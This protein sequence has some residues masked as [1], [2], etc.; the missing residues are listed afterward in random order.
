MLKN[1]VND[2]KITLKKSRKR[3]FRTPKM[4][5]NDHQNGQNEQILI[6]NLN[7][8]GHLSTFRAENIHNRWPFQAKNNAQTFSKE[9]QN[10]FEK[11]QKITF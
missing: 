4:V 5:K 6:E 8:R 3:L 9:V 10:N 1:S 11:F 7:F 2:S